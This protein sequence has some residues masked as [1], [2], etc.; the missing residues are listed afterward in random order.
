MAENVTLPEKGIYL[1]L[2]PSSLNP[3][4]IQGP[5]SNFVTS[6]YYIAMG[7]LT[8]F[9]IA[10]G[11]VGVYLLKRYLSKSSL[12][13]LPPGP[14]GKPIIGNLLD[15]PQPGEQEWVHWAKH[16]ELYSKKNVVCIGDIVY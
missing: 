1:C 5:V 8:Y 2:P 10:A 9:D 14:K 13:P 3:D 11:C 15:L 6:L 4:V 16:K 12:P 7:N